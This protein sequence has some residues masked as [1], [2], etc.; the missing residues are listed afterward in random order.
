MNSLSLFSNN[1]QKLYETIFQGYINNKFNSIYQARLPLKFYAAI[2]TRNLSPYQDIYVYKNIDQPTQFLLGKQSKHYRQCN[3][4]HKLLKPVNQKTLLL[5]T[6]K[7]YF[8]F[9]QPTFKYNLQTY[10][11]L[12][13]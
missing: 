9:I 12:F 2:N 1:F 7:I 8:M 11:L 6:I 13:Q 4:S 10:Q 3:K 5:E